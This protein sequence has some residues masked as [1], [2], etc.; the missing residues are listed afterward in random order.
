MTSPNPK[1]RDFLAMVKL[2]EKDAGIIFQGIKAAMAHEIADAGMGGQGNFDRERLAAANRLAH[3]LQLA[4]DHLII[5]FAMLK[6]SIDPENY[7]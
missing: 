3:H 4:S 5:G 6:K 2:H 7:E 1:A